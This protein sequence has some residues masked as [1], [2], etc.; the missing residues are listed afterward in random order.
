MEN[1]KI[2]VHSFAQ[3]CLVENKYHALSQQLRP[4]II[5]E[6]NLRVSSLYCWKYKYCLLSLKQTP[7]RKTDIGN[8]FHHF[9]K[10]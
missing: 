4:S 9:Q 8:M 3:N 5:F 2:V 10:N 1:T 6:M 7:F